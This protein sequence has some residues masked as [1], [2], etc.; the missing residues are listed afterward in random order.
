[1]GIEKELA[2]KACLEEGCNRDMRCFGSEKPKGLCFEAFNRYKN[3]RRREL[4]KEEDKHAI[5][6][7]VL[8]AFLLVFN[9]FFL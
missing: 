6:G 5:G 7:L 9:F 3:L 1:M 8:I 2:E 4:E